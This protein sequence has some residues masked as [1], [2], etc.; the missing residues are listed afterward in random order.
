MV[1]YDS[2]WALAS[3]DDDSVDDANTSVSGSQQPSPS[4][5]RHGDALS[6]EI[7]SESQSD[8]E[9]T[10]AVEEYSEETD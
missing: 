5:E 6:S 7:V 10:D 9:D 4:S 1:L 3:S 8:G 2:D